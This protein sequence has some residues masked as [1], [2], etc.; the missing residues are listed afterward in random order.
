MTPDG[1]LDPHKETE[2]AKNVKFASIRMSLKYLKPTR[3]RR[4]DVSR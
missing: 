3:I 1:D 2:N 4:R